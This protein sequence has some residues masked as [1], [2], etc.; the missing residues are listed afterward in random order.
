MVLW[1]YPAK[2][3]FRFYLH[4]LSTEPGLRWE[5]LAARSFIVRCSWLYLCHGWFVCRSVDLFQG[6]KGTKKPQRP[7][8]THKN[9]QNATKFQEA[10]EWKKWKSEVHIQLRQRCDQ[11]K[12]PQ[13]Q[14]FH[15]IFFER[16]AFSTNEVREFDDEK[17]VEATR[18]V[19][20]LNRRFFVSRLEAR[21]SSRR[22]SKAVR[23]ERLF[24]HS[25]LPRCTLRKHHMSSDIGASSSPRFL[26]FR[27]SSWQKREDFVAEDFGEVTRSDVKWRKLWRLWR[28]WTF[29]STRTTAFSSFV[30]FFEAKLQNLTLRQSSPWSPWC[31]ESGP[32]GPTVWSHLSWAK[33]VESLRN[34]LLSLLSLLSSGLGHE[35]TLGFKF[36]K[37]IMNIIRKHTWTIP[38]YAYLCRFMQCS[39]AE[40]KKIAGAHHFHQIPD[41]PWSFISLISL[42]QVWPWTEPK[43]S[44]QK[45]G[46]SKFLK[47]VFLKLTF[48]KH[49][50]SIPST[51]PFP[52]A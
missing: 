28:L 3:G 22:P 42:I 1:I 19:E 51:F 37:S 49:S 39:A 15:N 32:V 40:M 17:L 38:I 12:F 50:Q 43:W 25:L 41:N 16:C 35:F 46:S 20:K 26:R 10:E 6:R 13:P 44:L 36:S 47:K 9:L 48:L 18:K 14:H 52:K 7:T 21:R 4:Y 34:V 31:C 11:D 27:V 5:R 30:V 23:H 33:S 24:S 45:C 29:P 2:L 8:K